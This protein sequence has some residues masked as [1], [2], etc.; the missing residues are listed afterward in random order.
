MAIVYE[1]IFPNGKKYVGITTQ[2]PAKRWQRGNNYTHNP[3]LERAI[4]KYGW[5]NIQHMIIGEY[6]TAQEAGEVEKQLIA[7]Q[8]LQNPKYGYNISSG[9]EHGKHRKETIEKMSWSRMGANNPMYGMKGKLSP[10]YG[11][12]GSMLGKHLSEEA[13]EKISKANSGK[14]NGMFGRKLSEEQKEVIRIRLS[15]ENNKFSKRVLCVETGIIYASSGEAARKTG[16]HQGHISECCNGVH[17][18]TGGYHWRYA[19]G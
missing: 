10:R 16:C 12:P 6:E 14:N 18:T 15:G 1:H 9:G 17:K 5:D 19:N 11:K 8:S 3:H 7:E 2:R 13:K 4:Q